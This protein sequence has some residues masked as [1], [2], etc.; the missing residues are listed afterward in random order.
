VTQIDEIALNTYAKMAKDAD[1][2][3]KFAND[4]SSDPAVA[5][6]A[7]IT[8]KT[9]KE[10]EKKL[11][12]ALAHKPENKIEE[13]LLTETKRLATDESASKA[14]KDDQAIEAQAKEL[15]GIEKGAAS[16]V[17]KIQQGM[18]PIIKN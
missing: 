11:D 6:Y 7:A 16:Y 5:K 13:S 17:K 12:A 1:L 15:D 2:L 10:A 8:A 3:T 9:L 14:Q 18:A 4:K